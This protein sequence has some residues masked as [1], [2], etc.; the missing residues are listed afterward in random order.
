MVPH[1]QILFSLVPTIPAVIYGLGFDW[2]IHSAL[3]TSEAAAELVVK[4]VRDLADSIGM[5]HAMA[6]VKLFCITIPEVKFD[7]FL[8]RLYTEF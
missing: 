2:L 5:N 4:D 1:A 6:G 8:Y 3:L 7:Y